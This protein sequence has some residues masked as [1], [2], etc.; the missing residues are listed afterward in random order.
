MPFP[1][2]GSGSWPPVSPDTG[3]TVNT[4]FLDPRP[5]TI[6]WGTDYLWEDVT[7]NAIVKSM[8]SLRMIEEIRIENGTGL[9]ATQVI[10]NDGDQV[11]ITIIDD[12]AISFPDSGEVVTLINPI[13]EGGTPSKETFM[14]INNDY[15]AA[16]KVEGER[17]LLC[18][19]Y[20]LGIPY[21]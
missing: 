13:T 11:E 21:P 15:N 3:F 9:T 17:V 16:R 18:K 8:R 10:L 1:T 12:R 5:T 19:H 2:P 4:A 20:I 14:V 7:G 6:A